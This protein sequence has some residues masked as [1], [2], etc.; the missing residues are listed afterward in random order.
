MEHYVSIILVAHAQNVPLIDNK[1][2]MKTKIIKIKGKTPELKEINNLGTKG[3]CLDEVLDFY[4]KGVYSHTEYHYHK[5]PFIAHLKSFIFN[6]EK[7]NKNV[8][9]YDL[10]HIRYCFLDIFSFLW[11]LISPIVFGA[12]IPVGIALLITENQFI[13]CLSYIVYTVLW[14]W[15]HNKWINKKSWFSRQNL[16]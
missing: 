6:Y 16:V 15:I 8:I 11:I 2:I 14:F 10:Q 4:N 12:L 1:I 9:K 13:V 7:K 3:W 5:V